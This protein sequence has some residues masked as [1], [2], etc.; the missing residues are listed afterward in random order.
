MDKYI[1]G[2]LIEKDKRKTAQRFLDAANLDMETLK[3]R[4]IVKDSSYYKF[5]ATK[6]DGFIYHMQTVTML[7]RTPSDVVEYLKNPLNEEL[8]ID[9]TKKVEKYWNA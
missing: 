7:G 5:I 4:A 3:I 8:L 6:A 2:D 9:L 1:N